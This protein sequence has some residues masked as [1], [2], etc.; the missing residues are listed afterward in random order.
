V[1][2]LS[3]LYILREVM[4][5]IKELD[6]EDAAPNK[7]ELGARLPLPCNYFDFIIGTSTGGYV[8]RHSSKRC[9][10]RMC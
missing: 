2:G 8:I 6:N 5:R 1:R 9:T 10:S 7:M 3:S 4:Q